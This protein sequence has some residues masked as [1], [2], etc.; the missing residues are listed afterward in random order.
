MGGVGTG[1]RGR[2][3]VSVL[4]LPIRA[5]RQAPKPPA[6]PG[7]LWESQTEETPGSRNVS[8]CASPARKRNERTDVGLRLPGRETL[9]ASPSTERVPGQGWGG[10]RSREVRSTPYGAASPFAI[11]NVPAA[12]CQ[13]RRAR[14]RP[15]PDV[16]G[17]LILDMRRIPTL[18]VRGR[19]ILHMR[20]CP[21]PPH[22][23]LHATPL[24]DLHAEEG[25][26]RDRSGTGKQCT[27]P[28]WRD[29]LVF[30]CWQ[31]SAQRAQSDL[32][33]AGLDV[34]R[35]RVVGEGQRKPVTCSLLLALLAPAN[36]ILM[37]HAR[38]R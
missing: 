16:R 23:G 29:R 18:D 15:I 10:A 3:F 35:L 26:T 32:Q 36:H 21:V 1:P 28:G 9:S 31:S 34:P 25:C 38:T 6:Q 30:I 27:Q 14:K 13:H 11:C 17:H 19:L 22:G 33:S 20:G 37:F 8:A 7:V 12:T 2:F 5:G 24:L 4:S